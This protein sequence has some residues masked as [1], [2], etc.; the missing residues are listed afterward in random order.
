MDGFRIRRDGE[1]DLDARDL[2]VVDTAMNMRGESYFYTVSRIMRE[3]DIDEAAIAIVDF[4]AKECLDGVWKVAAALSEKHGNE[5]AS[6]FLSSFMA[7]MSLE[8]ADHVLRG[9][10]LDEAEEILKGDAEC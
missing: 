2:E 1:P 8:I 5:A 10:L 9:R 3:F 6:L 4:S 7:T